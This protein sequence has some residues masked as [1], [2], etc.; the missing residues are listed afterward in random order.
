VR[1]APEVPI[2]AP[3]EQAPPAAPAPVTVRPVPPSPA[4][5]APSAAPTASPAES[6]DDDE[7]GETIV[8]DRRPRIRA[9]LQVEGGPAIPLTA[10]RVVLGRKPA[11]GAPGTQDLAV[12]DTTRTLSKVHARVE[13]GEEG[14]IITDLESTNGVVVVASDG[15]ETL[16]DRGA[17][18]PVTGRF[19]LG[20]VAMSIVEEGASA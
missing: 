6:A 17:S 9:V 8:V 15:T 4:V 18:S 16:L 13:R 1:P 5:G 14:W 3:A 10:D 19:I 7:F 11:G 20:K 12:P 2:T